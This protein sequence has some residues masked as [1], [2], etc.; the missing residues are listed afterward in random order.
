MIMNQISAWRERQK[1]SFLTN[2]Q[3]S[4]VRLKA[5]GLKLEIGNGRNPKVKSRTT[6]YW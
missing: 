3:R 4:A 2:L 6:L 5:K 1:S